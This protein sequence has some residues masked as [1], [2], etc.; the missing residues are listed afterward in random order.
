[1]ILVSLKKRFYVIFRICVTVNFRFVTKAELVYDDLQIVYSQGHVVPKKNNDW[2]HATITMK[3]DYIAKT[4]LIKPFGL[5]EFTVI[6]FC[7]G[8]SIW[9]FVSK[10]FD[11][12]K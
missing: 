3:Q 6:V 9:V 7:S 5:Y 12:T 11:T 4:S 10:D 2:A 8:V 1:M